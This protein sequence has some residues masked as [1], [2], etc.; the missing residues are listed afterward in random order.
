[1]VSRE[2]RLKKQYEGLMR[3]AEKH[4]VKVETLDGRKDTTK[5]Y[6]LK[7]AENF[8]KRAQER[9]EILRRIGKVEGERAE[10]EN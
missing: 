2:K 8:E 7:E 9:M 10:D 3:Q 5:A 6:W 1:M 4:K